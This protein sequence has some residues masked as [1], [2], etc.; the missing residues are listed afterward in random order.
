V[1]YPLVELVKHWNVLPDELLGRFGIREQDL[2]EPQ[3]R[4]PHA[5]Y[6]AIIEH[7]RT[8]TG[9][10]ALG[11]FWGLQMR[12]SVFGYLGFATMSTATLRNA[13]DLAIEFA[14][15]GSTAEGMRL[16]VEGEVA[17]LVLEEHADFGDVRDVVTV[18]R[19]TGLWRIAEAL[20][21]RDL[22]AT[23]EAAIPE[24]SYH[25]RFAHRV[26][27]I[28][29]G[30]PTTRALMKAEVLDFPLVSADPVALRLATEQCERELSA[31]SAG[32]RM[33][34]TVRGLFWRG[35]G[36]FRSPREVADAVHMSPRT[37][38]R[39]LEAQGTSL[40]SLLDEERRDRAMMLLRSPELS[41]AQVA[42]RLGYGNAQN[43][44]RAFRRW[45]GASPATYRRT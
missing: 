19:L 22:H 33:V 14:P 10:E 25:A 12:I 4:F 36:G 13:I 38:R 29:Y 31:L 11:F 1:L 5:V 32:G 16:H 41:V 23:A 45:T 37:L 2:T 8:L 9:E 30:R 39:K 28:R 43:F 42:D 40:S 27:E 35:E 20:T 17:S 21:G 44:E 6:I 7:A 15:L 3:T 34:R 26:P 24:P 18:A